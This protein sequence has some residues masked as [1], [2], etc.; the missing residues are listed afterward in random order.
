MDMFFSSKEQ[1]FVFLGERKRK[2]GEDT[3]R[4]C[5]IRNVLIF[6]GSLIKI[7]L[8]RSSIS[9]GSYFYFREMVNFYFLFF[10][11]IQPA[12]PTEY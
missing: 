12:R 10:F 11:F 4:V 2:E 7:S 8:N 5:L 3:W 1:T 9:H 6:V